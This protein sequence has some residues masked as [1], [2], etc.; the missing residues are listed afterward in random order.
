M[1]NRTWLVSSVM[2]LCLVACGSSTD[3]FDPP[4]V[5]PPAAPAV[6]DARFAVA[7][8]EPW[9]L[10]GNA[11]TD[12][13]DTVSITVDAPADAEVV[14]VWVAGGPGQ[15]LTRD[16]ATP[17]RFTGDLAVGLLDAG[18]HQILIAANAADTAAFAVTFNRTHPFYFIM[19][20]DWDFAEPGQVALDY[21]D[22]L[23]AEHPSLV[24]THFIGP[25]TF[26]DPNLAEVRKAE[27]AAWAIE[28]RDQHDDEIAL[29]IHPWCHF[30]LAAGVE[31]NTTLSTVYQTD[32]TGYTIKLEA[33]G[34]AGFEMLLDKA[35]ELFLERGMGKPVTF[36]A[37]GWTAVI[38]TL[39]ALAAKGYIA[40]TSANN[41]MRMEEW[42]NQ[43]NLYTWNMTNWSTI[44]DTSQPYYPNTTDKQSAAPPT[45]SILEV[46]DN[47]IMVDYVTVQ[48]MTG[49]FNA[50]W[51]PG[52]TL[53]MPRTFMM[54]FHPSPNMTV[55]EYRRLDG[56]LD[57]AD[58]YLAS[59]HR[60]PVVYARLK[61]MPLVWP[62]P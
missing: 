34:Q 39:K 62:A 16:A 36:R 38:E 52:T 25:Y 1:R 45:V 31:C 15:R 43:G 60:G 46:P 24:F 50:N 59:Q 44:G 28:R 2:S 6:N 13:Q 49:I 55:D 30:V 57:H 53:S 54:G 40:D 32:T 42:R 51:P 3:G 20:T 7:G 18:T 56:I 10:V 23:R 4:S 22:D 8:V 21:H 41:W 29:H 26:T 5:T 12:G 61:D 47:A 37:G 48:E 19:T 11:L 27:L 14:D 35:D 9:Y 58:M 33:Y 17:T